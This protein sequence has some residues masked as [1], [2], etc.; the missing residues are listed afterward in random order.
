MIRLWYTLHA[1][2]HEQPSGLGSLETLLRYI[3]AAGRHVIVKDVRQALE[4]V[5]PQGGRLM[6]TILQTI[7]DAIEFVNSPEELRQLYRQT[8]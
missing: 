8:G 6:G 7:A 1:Q 4:I 3:P 5:L 2:V